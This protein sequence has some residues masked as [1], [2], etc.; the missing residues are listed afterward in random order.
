MSELKSKKTVYIPMCADIV[1]VGHLNIISEGNKHGDVT[2]GLLTDAAIAS[3]KR[4][5]LMTYDQRQAVVAGLKGVSA[6]IPQTTASYK[7]NLEQLRPDYV[8]HGDDWSSAARQSVIDTISKWGGELIELPYTEGIS[9]TLIQKKLKATGVSPQER[10]QSLKKIMGMKDT[11]RV[12]EAHNGLSALVVEQAT[13][14]NDSGHARWFDAVWFSSLTVSASKGKPDT[15]LVDLTS[16]VITLQDILDVTSKPVIVDG[17]SGGHA[18]HFAHTVRTLER[19][20]VSAIVIEDKIGL[21]RNSLHKNSAHHQQDSIVN[22][23]EKITAGVRA[24]SSQDFMIIARIESL[25]L[26]NGQQDA[27]ERAKAYIHA[28]A[29]AIMIHSKDTSGDDI[30][31]FCAA[32]NTLEQRAPLMLVPTS[33]NQITETELS[34]WGANIIVHAN[35]LLRVAYPAMI[36]AT[37]SILKHER[38]LELENDCLSIEEL[39]DLLTGASHEAR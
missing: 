31:A 1:H 13:I 36:R 8:V 35:H 21:K 28:G 18:E 4:I 29:D 2:V 3:K 16:Q 32:Y 7:E 6:V 11:V 34:H 15:E 30:H 22:F 24:R 19:L 38:T 20:G 5:P 12:L 23:S 33:Y 26:G 14:K 10:V 39:L 9:S 27:L 17:D 25:I 37:E